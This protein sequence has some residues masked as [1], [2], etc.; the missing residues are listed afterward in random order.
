MSKVKDGNYIVIQSFMVND[1]QLKGTELLIYAIIYGFSQDGEQK[2]TGSLQ[3]LADWTNSTKQSIINNL[4]SLVEKGLVG[5]KENIINGVKFIE[6]YSKNFNGG[7]QKILIPIK[8]ILPNNIEYNINNNIEYNNNNIYEFV[9]NNFGR[10]LNAIEYEEISKWEDNELT[11]Y[12]IKQA[13]LKGK[14][15]IK[16]I[17][18]VIDNYKKNNI[19]T[20]QQAQQQEQDYKNKKD[21]TKMTAQEKRFEMY[22]RLEK[23]YDN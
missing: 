9:E 19:I 20:I 15:A 10:T 11:R 1:L 22:K 2:F 3:Y 17:S 18:T 12:A 5:K 16:Y 7:I 4:K 13:I 14:Y 21:G 23:E 8:K 6:Y